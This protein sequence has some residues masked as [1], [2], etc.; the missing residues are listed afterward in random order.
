MRAA[1]SPS[2]LTSYQNM[3][4]VDYTAQAS[5]RSQSAAAQTQIVTYCKSLPVG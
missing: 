4:L 2:F 5:D 3:Y 1:S